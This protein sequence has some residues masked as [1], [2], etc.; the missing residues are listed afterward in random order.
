MWILVLTDHFT[1]W[2]D[3]IAIPNATAPTV[4]GVLQE[5]IFCYFGLL[6]VIHTDQGA[7]FE[8]DL[9]QELCRLWGVDKSRTTPYRPKGNGIVERN[10]RVLG[11]SLRALLT[12]RGQEEWDLILPHLMRTLR[13]IPHSATKETPNF[14]LLGRELR[15][16]DQLQYG[17]SIEYFSSTNEYT[18]AIQNRLLQ[19]H[20]LLR[21]RQQEVVA[22]DTQEP[23]LFNVGDQVW[24]VSK[25]R[26]KGENSKLSAKFVDLYRVGVVSTCVLTVWNAVLGV[27]LHTYDLAGFPLPSKAQQI[28]PRVYYFLLSFYAY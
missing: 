3:A 12:G 26:R 6:E 25:R 24:M 19:A 9:F 16:P 27:Q 18:Q 8:S 14:M 17:S 4:V 22:T 13:G 2:S 7:Q 21:K 10:N 15:L 11:D 23:P 20:E 28:W 5:R 1:Q